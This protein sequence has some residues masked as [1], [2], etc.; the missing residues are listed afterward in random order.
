MSP[1]SHRRTLE[2]WTNLTCIDSLHD[3]SLVVLG[4]NVT[5]P[6][7]DTYTTRL[8]LA[9]AKEKTMPSLPFPRPYRKL[10]ATSNMV[11]ISGMREAK[12]VIRSNRLLPKKY[13]YTCAM[14]FILY[15]SL[16]A[17]R[18]VDTILRPVV[19]SFTARHPETSFQQDNTAPHTAHI[20]LNRLR[21][22]F[23]PERS[24]ASTG[25]SLAECNT[26][27]I[28]NLYPSLSRRLQVHI[29]PRDGSNSYRFEHLR[30]NSARGLLATDHVIFNHGQGTWTTPELAPASPN[31]HTTPMGGR[32]SSRQ[33]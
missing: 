5:R 1:L 19:L 27:D 4:S 18:Y 9:T 26:D 16:K 20:A 11:C 10:R 29:T 23:W 21:T 8:P 3:G 33:I 14:F 25:E 13:R 22:V 30:C 7:S 2:L 17:Q 15:T 12:V 31:Y 28:R 32:F 6:R 24:G